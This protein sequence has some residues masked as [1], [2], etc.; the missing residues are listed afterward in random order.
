LKDVLK[1][2]PEE[3]CYIKGG[4][5]TK[6][7][8]IDSKIKEEPSGI[9]QLTRKRKGVVGYIIGEEVISDM[10]SPLYASLNSELAARIFEEYRQASLKI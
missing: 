6:K 1:K 4:E 8:G 9:Y 5:K 7:L 10:V 3:E 2:F